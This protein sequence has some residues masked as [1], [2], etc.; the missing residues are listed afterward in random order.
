MLKAWMETSQSLE[1]QMGQYSGTLVAS[2][3][4]LPKEL[5]TVAGAIFLNPLVPEG[6]RYLS[7]TQLPTSPPRGSKCGSW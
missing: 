5:G 3:V 7:P 6:G 4:F 2:S 1:Q